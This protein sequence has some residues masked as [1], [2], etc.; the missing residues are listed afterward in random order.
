[1]LPTID[2]NQS[3]IPKIVYLTKQGVLIECPHVPTSK[4]GINDEDAVE[5]AKTIHCN[6][7]GY[8]RDAT[9]NNLSIACFHPSS[10]YLAKVKQQLKDTAQKG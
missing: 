7:C 4:Q 9:I 6:R 8:L 2:A 5:S 10:P 3:K 1:M